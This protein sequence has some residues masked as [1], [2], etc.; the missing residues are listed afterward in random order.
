MADYHIQLNNND[1]SRL[2]LRLPLYGAWV[3]ECVHSDP[4]MVPSVGDTAT[5]VLASQTFVGTVVRV[6]TLE[7]MSYD[8]LVVGGGGGLSLRLEP[9]Q[10]VAP[11]V[12][13]VISSA[14]LN[15]GEGLSSTTSTSLLQTQVASWRRP[16]RTLGRELDAI[17]EA[18]GVGTSWRVLSD[19]SVRIG[20]EPETPTPANVQDYD[21]MSWDAAQGVVVI[22]SEDP[23]VLPGENWPDFGM[24]GAVIHNITPE[25]TRTEIYTADPW[26]REVGAFDSLLPQLDMLAFYQYKV[27]SQNSDGTLE[28]R[29]LD[30]R[31]PDL[32]RCPARYGIPGTSGTI[33]SGC[34]VVVGFAGGNSQDPYVASWVSGTAT[35]LTIRASTLLEL[36]SSPATSFV[37]LASITDAD[38]NQLKATL[39]SWTPVPGDGGTALKTLLTTLFSTGWPTS[40]AATKVKAT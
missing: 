39:V 13:S 35:N 9:L 32:S 26:D 21:T 31:L 33:P 11:L 6:S 5:I 3:G 19:G 16:T 36:G 8:T 14:L 4:T 29:T 18:L 22:A 7:D 15:T 28:L 38:L 27:L 25:E 34:L 17:C 37:S 24:I 40:T 30:Q 20:T 23:T 1:L 10:L 2:R 12:S